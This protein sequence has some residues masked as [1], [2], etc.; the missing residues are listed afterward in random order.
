MS[1]FRTF[2]VGVDI[3]DIGRFKGLGKGP[4]KRI[5][6]EDEILY[7]SKKGHPE[8]HFAARFVAKEAVLKAL[9][10]MGIVGC[11]LKKIE[12]VNDP[13]GAP[14][15]RFRDFEP[16]KGL[17]ITLSISH[18]KGSAVSVAMVMRDE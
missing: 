17:T 16:A 12:I 3:E 13:K 15:V 18:N 1:P 10:S 8:V 4:M 11:D 7:C 5:F 14:N 6:T 2:G 9:G